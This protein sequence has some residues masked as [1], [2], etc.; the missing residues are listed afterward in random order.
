MLGLTALMLYLGELLGGKS[1]LMLGL[2]FAVVSNFFSYFFSD[3]IVLALYRAKPVAENDNPGLYKI[4]RELAQRAN[5]PMPK[6]YIIPA[7]YAN[8]F[9]TGRNPNHAAVAVTQGILDLLSERELRGVLAHEL[10][11]VTNRDILISTVAAI[12]ASAIYTIARIAQWSMWLGGSSDRN[13]RRGNPLG[14]LIMVIVAPLA[15]MIIQMAISRNRE[16]EADAD[17]A[18][19][20]EDPMA[21][22]DALQKISGTD[23]ALGSMVNPTTAHLFIINPLKGE[24]VF[25]LFSTHPPLAKR[26]SRLEA[27][28]NQMGKGTLRYDVPKIIY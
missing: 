8:A 3:K 25:A 18:H 10:S 27:I 5:M 22:A 9:A 13:N 28:A 1:G 16:Y 17:G 7:S 20:S 26:V 21:L 11:H 14:L 2:G 24:D 6:L 23:R 12:A 4:V 19:L 15:A